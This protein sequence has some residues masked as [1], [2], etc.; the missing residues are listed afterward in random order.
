VK[1][2]IMIKNIISVMVVLGLATPGIAMKIV[3]DSIEEEKKRETN[4]KN[5]TNIIN[6][7]I[8]INNNEKIISEKDSIFKEELIK[9]TPKEKKL[10]ETVS[11]FN[12]ENV[13]GAIDEQD[14]KNLVRF[15]EWNVF[16][17]GSRSKKRL[18][19]FALFF[20]DTRKDATSYRVLLEVRAWT[21]SS[22]KKKNQKRWHLKCYDY[23]GETKRSVYKIFLDENGNEEKEMRF[24]VKEVT[25]PLYQF[26]EEVSDTPEPSN[27][28]VLLANYWIVK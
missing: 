4:N 19:P 14:A 11:N 18:L 12:L 8:I 17:D 13:L 9:E 27:T 25:H 6:N 28:K 26:I 22:W 3:D 7:I 23:L 21:E 1:E 10:V 15:H 24:L 5:A 2:A 16:D 20:E